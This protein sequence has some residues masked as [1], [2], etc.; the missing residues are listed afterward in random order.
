MSRPACSLMAL[1][2]AGCAPRGGPGGAHWLASSALPGPPGS[3]RPP[4]VVFLGGFSGPAE[5][6]DAVEIERQLTE[7]MHDLSAVLDQ[8]EAVSQDGWRLQTALL[9]WFSQELGSS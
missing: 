6:L 8:L 1:T 7:R 3:P 9:R 5:P 2:S 4:E